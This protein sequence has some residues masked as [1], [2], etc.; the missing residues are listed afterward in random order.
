MVCADC[1]VFA[2]SPV[3]GACRALKRISGLLRSGHLKGE[4]E[5]RVAE[6]LRGAAGELT[7]LVEENLPKGRADLPPPGQEATTGLTSGPPEAPAAK[8]GEKGESEYTEESS[9]EEVAVEETAVEPEGITVKAEGSEE[10]TTH[11]ETAE[12]APEGTGARDGGDRAGDELENPG[13]LALRPVPKASSRDTRD[14]GRHR[15]SDRGYRRAERSPRRPVSPERRGGGPRPGEREEDSEGRPPLARRP[16]KRQRTRERGTKGERHRERA[17]EFTRKKIEERRRKKAAKQCPQKQK[18]RPKRWVGP[19]RWVWGG[20]QQPGLADKRGCWTPPTALA[21][22][23]GDP[24]QERKAARCGSRGWKRSST[25]SPST[26]SDLP[27]GST[28]VLWTAVWSPRAE[29]PGMLH[30]ALVASVGPRAS[31]FDMEIHEDFWCFMC[32]CKCAKA[33]NKPCF[34]IGVHAQV[35]TQSCRCRCMQ[36]ATQCVFHGLQV[37]L[38]CKCMQTATQCVFHGLQVNLCCKCMQTATQCFFHGLQVNLCCKCMQTATQCFFHWL[39]GKLS[40]KCSEPM[41]L[42]QKEKVQ[43]TNFYICVCVY[44]YLYIKY[45]TGW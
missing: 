9:E 16:P 5:R 37:N 35:Q 22:G 18:Q 31:Y 24:L 38:C 36:T 12:A 6:I 19:G 23:G 7:D 21:K 28:A 44:K 40:C 32:A 42:E 17:R 29:P 4:Q 15:E 13:A 30:I 27:W 20:G 43:V 11:R 25:R 14:R 41:R 39:Q 8:K 3:C 45:G 33:H 1:G 26:F 10:V 34:V 2:A